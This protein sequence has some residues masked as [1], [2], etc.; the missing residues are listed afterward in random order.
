MH[1]MGVFQGNP[2]S[3]YGDNGESKS[4]GEVLQEWMAKISDVESISLHVRRGDYL[5]PENQALF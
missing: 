2:P 3:G 5:L 1:N 4:A